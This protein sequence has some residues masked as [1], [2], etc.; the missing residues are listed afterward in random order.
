MIPGSGRYSGEGIGYPLQ[1]SLASLM[2]Q[3]V[4]NL[5]CG[6]PCFEPIEK[7]PWRRERL[8]TPVLWP[9]EFQGLYS[10]CSHKES[11]TTERHSISVDFILGF[12]SM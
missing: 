5:K 6:R 2:A 3:L 8:P 4:K 7:I 11:D 12:L 10:P 9:G 1:Y